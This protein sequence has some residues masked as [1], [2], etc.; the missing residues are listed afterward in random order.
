MALLYHMNCVAYFDYHRWPRGEKMARTSIF[1]FLPFKS[2]H[3]VGVVTH[4]L[5]SLSCHE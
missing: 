2:K 1:F 4:I 3:I 5:S